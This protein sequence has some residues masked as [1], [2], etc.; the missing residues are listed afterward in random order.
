M[1]DDSVSESTSELTT[2]P[3]ID[4]NTSFIYKSGT[5]TAIGNYNSPGG[6]EEID[7]KIVLEDDVVVDAEVISRATRP[8]SITMQGQFV[9]GFKEQVVGKYLDEVL[10]DKVSGSSLT[11]KGFNEAIAE[12]KEQARA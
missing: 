6:A 10:L 11:P 4:P 5:Y 9:S 2:L 3:E 12:I 8:R 7:V 1:K